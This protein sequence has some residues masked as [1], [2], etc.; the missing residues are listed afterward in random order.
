MNGVDVGILVIVGFSAVAGLQRGF[1]L[2]MVDLFAFA[3]ALLAAGRTSELAA[4][5]LR[6]RGFPEPLA[7]GAGFFI[8]LVVA[9]AIIGLAVRV[10]L[11]PLRSF[12]SGTPLAWVNGVLGLLPG[13]LRGLAVAA[14]AVI[15][16]SALPPEIGLRQ[17]MIGSQLAEPLATSG[18]EALDAGLEWAGVDP[19]TLGLPGIPRN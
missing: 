9:Y 17:Q 1:M 12:G 5:L 4:G 2:G 3:I 15:A 8:A 13:A 14:L 11:S 6:E 7:S 16:L 18:K 19:G 10:L